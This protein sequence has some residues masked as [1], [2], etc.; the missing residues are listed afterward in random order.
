MK[1]ITDYGAFVDLGGVDGLLHITDM[2][3]GRIGHPSEVVNVGDKVRVVVLKYDPERERVS[4][5][6]KQILPDPWATVH[7]RYAPGM[8]VH[9]KVVSLTDYGAFIELEKG[10]E[11]LDPRLGD[12]VDPA[13]EPSIQGAAG[14]LRGRCARARRRSRQPPHLARPE[15][16]RAESVGDGPHQSSDRQPHRRQGEEHHRLRRLRRRRRGHR[17]PGAHLRSAL[18][19][20]GE[21]PVRALQEG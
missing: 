11:G 8:K 19:E 4:L 9:G 21:A 10:V 20:E 17:R 14:R 5:G 6:M 1:N 2:S 18:D 13:G 3:W 7:E 15:A 16:D 12:V